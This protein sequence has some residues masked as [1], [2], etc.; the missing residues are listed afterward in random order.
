MWTE[1]TDHSVI[2][3]N[4]K[5]NGLKLYTDYYNVPMEKDLA[6]IEIRFERTEVVNN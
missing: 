3:E 6:Y 5:L 2:N 1:R 4:V